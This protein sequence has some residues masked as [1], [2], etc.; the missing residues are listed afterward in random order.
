MYV[1]HN[2]CARLPDHSCSAKTISIA[3]S[4]CVFVALLIQ[5]AM[6]MRHTV[7]CVLSGCTIFLHIISQMAILK[8]KVTKRKM[9]VLTFS[10]TFV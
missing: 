10:T 1:Y 2:T 3:Y 4:E 6:R 9:R 5:H 7:V 8:K